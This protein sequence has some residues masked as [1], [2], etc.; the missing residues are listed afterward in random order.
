MLIE[1]LQFFNFGVFAGTQVIDFSL[2]KENNLT[3][4]FA[5]NSGGK[6]TIMRGLKFLFYG[7]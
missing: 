7:K 5:A 4:I 2:K 6:T 3:V 1:R